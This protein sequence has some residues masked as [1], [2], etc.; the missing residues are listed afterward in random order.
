MKKRPSVLKGETEKVQTGCGS[1]YLTI[2]EDEGGS[3]CEMRLQMGKS[4]SCVRSMLEVIGILM[5]IILQNVDKGPAINA[6][7]KHL[8]G[9]SCGQ[10][11]REGD[12]RYASCLDKIAHRVLIK[13]KEEE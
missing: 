5:S 3:P 13:L 10:E 6:L 9:V 1:L 12:A 7:K 11:F 8:R 4:G 2:N